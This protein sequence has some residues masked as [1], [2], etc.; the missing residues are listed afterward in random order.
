MAAALAVVLTVFGSAPAVSAHTDFDFSLPAEGATVGEPVSEITIGFTDPVTL[1]GNGFKVLDPQGNVLEPFAVTDDDKVFRL[2]LDP[3]LAGGA[4]GVRYEVA[5]AD[6]HVIGGS[7]AFTVAAPAPTEP[8]PTTAATTAT[9]AA[10][11]TAV[12]A[13]SAPA[14]AIAPES[15]VVTVV[16]AAATTPSTSVTEQAVSAGG[17][18]SAP[19]PDDESDGST[20]T[21]V[22]AI[23][24]AVA[25]G[26]AGFVLI[27]SRVAPSGRPPR[28]P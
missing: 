26:A 24:V 15:T 11:A 16:V 17:E 27:R 9:T 8:P 1:V 12:P 25:V 20:R 4:V 23:A 6:G 28:I 10:P 22:I 3:P 2:Q 13:G 5:A 7:F 21:I 14:S 19:T 18:R